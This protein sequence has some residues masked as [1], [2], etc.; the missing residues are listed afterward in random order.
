MSTDLLHL[1]EGTVCM[2]DLYDCITEILAVV[3]CRRATDLFWV[4]KTFTRRAKSLL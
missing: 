1:Y 3:S 2:Y 4:G